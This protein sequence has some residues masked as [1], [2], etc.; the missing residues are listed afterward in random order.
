[1]RGPSAQGRTPESGTPGFRIGLSIAATVSLA[2]GFACSAIYVLAWADQRIV[3]ATALEAFEE[4]RTVASLSAADQT[5]AHGRARQV[6]LADAPDQGD[7]SEQR[8]TEYRE[9]LLATIAPPPGVLTI[10]SIGLRVPIFDGTSDLVLNRGVGWIEGTAAPGVLGNLGLAGHRDGFFRGLKDLKVGDVIEVRT[11]E[12]AMRYRVSETLIVQP[13]DVFVLEP[14]AEASVT[15][16]TCYPFYFVGH[17][18][19]RYIVKGKL[20]S[21]ST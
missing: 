5:E 18:P 2:L 8:R 19:Q 15:L 20:D 6:A 3:N 12:R 4:A 21:S 7:W 13:S 11:V 14:T 9:S 10:P 16:V 1:M 17:A